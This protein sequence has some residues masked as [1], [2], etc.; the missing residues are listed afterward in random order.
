MFDTKQKL[1]YCLPDIDYYTTLIRKSFIIFCFWFL[2]RNFVE[3]SSCVGNVAFTRTGIRPPTNVR[4]PRE[5]AVWPTSEISRHYFL[6]GLSN[7]HALKEIFSQNNVSTYSHEYNR[8]YALNLKI[9]RKFSTIVWSWLG[10]VQKNA[11]LRPRTAVSRTERYAGKRWVKA[12]RCL[13]LKLFGQCYIVIVMLFSWII[14]K[15]KLRFGRKNVGVSRILLSQQ[16]WQNLV[17]YNPETIE[18]LERT[19]VPFWD[20]T[21]SDSFLLTINVKGIIYLLL[22]HDLSW[23]TFL[24]RLSL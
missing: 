12:E 17:F 6:S 16:K 15:V 7:Y 23:P 8:K 21:W 20:V 10:A 1:L 3:D 2:K 24:L 11:D 5:I 19:N 9:I 4:G 18:W 13:A 22:L 14:S